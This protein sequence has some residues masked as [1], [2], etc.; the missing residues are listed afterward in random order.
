MS[1]SNKTKPIQK[2]RF[3]IVAVI[4]VFTVFLTAPVLGQS[5]TQFEYFVP[6]RFPPQVYPAS[7]WSRFLTIYG[8]ENDTQVELDREF[9]GTVDVVIPVNRSEFVSTG[10]TSHGPLGPT[11]FYE[12]THLRTNKPIL[13]RYGHANNDYG[14]Y[15]DFISTYVILPT[16]L[17][18]KEFYVPMSGLAVSVVACQD[19]T[20]LEVDTDHDGIVD[21]TAAID[22]GHVTKLT[23]I[24]NGSHVSANKPVYMVA[25]HYNSSNKD[26]FWTYEV[27]PVSLQGKEYY[28]P[29]GSPSL[30]KLVVVSTQSDCLLQVDQDGDGTY[31]INQVLARGQVFEVTG[32]SSGAHIL[33]DKIICAAYKNDK[34]VPDPW[35]G[36]YRHYAYAYSLFPTD[37]NKF[38]FFKEFCLG[39]LPYGINTMTLLSI[40]DNNSLCVDIDDNG[41]VDLSN[42]LGKGQA[43]Q[44]TASQPTYIYGD[45]LFLLTGDNWPVNFDP[46]KLDGHLHYPIIREF[47][48]SDNF[49]STFSI[50]AL[51]S[52]YM[53]T[54]VVVHSGN[55][56]VIDESSEPKFG[57]DSELVLSENVYFH[58]E[59][60]IYA[61]RVKIKTRSSVDDVYCNFI[62]NHATI[63]GDIN[64]PLELPLDVTLPEFPSPAPGTVDIT[65]AESETLTLPPGAYGE[66][67]LNRLAT[68]IL[69]GGTYHVE[70]LEMGDYTKVLVQ[71]PTLLLIDNR[72]ESGIKPIIRPS[73]DSEITASDIR[74]YVHGMNGTGGGLD[75]LPRAVTI[76][77]RHALEANIFAP[78]GTIW[79][80][81]RGSVE[82]A[83]VGKDIMIDFY[84]QV[85][86]NSAF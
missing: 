76:G 41:T 80:K 46:E 37:H 38:Q 25:Y 17:W 8:F 65:L 16:T 35:R 1:A 12:G 66:I 23:G 77:I 2:I 72:L 13:L 19:G 42:I 71:S 50:F 44:F 48:E 73:E 22:A 33:S 47:Y 68:L 18:G 56:G 62:V 60:S 59:A 78:N 3:L 55:A 27:L 79:L 21:V 15:D 20:V 9:D 70:N 40:E 10:Y 63:R 67:K 69:E 74:I 28:V 82:G 86:L 34:Y 85:T 49:L 57:V 4:A 58:D 36:V 52:I 54:G 6:L 61:H 5:S 39:S 84:V 53:R 51:N 43:W 29:E 11:E 83:F 14:M 64:T 7:D 45:H 26:D 81:A 32:F 30:S 75:E 24:P 31:D